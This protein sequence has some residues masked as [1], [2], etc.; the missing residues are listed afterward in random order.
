MERVLKL[1][2][3]LFTF[4]VFFT[5]FGVPV[6]SWARVDYE[7]TKPFVFPVSPSAV[8]DRVTVRTAEEF[9]PMDMMP[10]QDQGY[11]FGNIADRSIQ[12][13]WK[14]S[15]FRYTSVGRVAQDLEK[16]LKTD[17]TIRNNE[18]PRAVEHK[19]SVQL[20]AAQ[21]IARLEYTGWIKAAFKYYAREAKSET[22]IREKVFDNKDLV[23]SHTS[24][25]VEEMSSLLL[26]W[27]W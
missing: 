27:T 18:G 19:F 6:F 16:R 15:A 11:V 12:Y 2:S 24:T 14:N 10:S 23:L 13:F 1:G 9:I 3:Y 17:I 22:Q 20:L 25:S 4:A 7:K 5:L 8:G 21:A 26:S